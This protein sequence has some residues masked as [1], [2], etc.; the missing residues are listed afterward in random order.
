MVKASA[1]KEQQMSGL[2][3]KQTIAAQ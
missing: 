3:Q 2:G 1:L